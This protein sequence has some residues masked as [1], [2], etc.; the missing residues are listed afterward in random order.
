MVVIDA[1]RVGHE[2]LWKGRGGY[3]AVVETFGPGILGP[4]GGID[5]S[6][7]ADVVFADTRA[8][9]RLESIL[10]P[11]IL[12]LV[13][14]RIERLARRRFAVVV[15][16]AALLVESGFDRVVDDF[17]VV[18]S[19]EREQVARLVRGRRMDPAA[20]RARIRAQWPGSR[21]AR[22]ARWVVPNDGTREDLEREAQRVHREMNEHPATRR[23]RDAWRRRRP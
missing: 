23:L 3:A 13:H 18:L 15:L 21:K 12:A 7:L 14:R 19:E 20:A 1:D 9:R 2:L 5:R 6:R 11:R 8:R 17:V 22:A 4:R 16:E 10:H